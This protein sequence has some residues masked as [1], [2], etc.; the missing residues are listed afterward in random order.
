MTMRHESTTNRF[1]QW[2]R[3]QWCAAAAV[4]LA[5]L[6]RAAAAAPSSPVAL[7][8]CPA[9]DAGVAA[10]LQKM[11]DQLG[12]IGKLVAG[13]TVAI[14]IN[15]TGSLRTRSG[16]RPAWSNRWTHPAVIAAAVGLIGKAGARRIRVL[17]GSSEDD[18]PLEENFVIGGWDPA[19]ILGAG[20]NVEMENTG[21]LGYGKEYKRLEVPGGGTIYSAFDLNHSYAECDVMVSMAKMKEDQH[22]GLSLSLKNMV[23]I[24]PGTIYGDSAGTDQPAERPFGGRSMFHL[25][26]RQPPEGTPPEKDPNSPRLPGYRI[27]RITVDLARARPVDLAII[28]GIET[29]TAASG[30]PLDTGQGREIR[31]VKPGILIASL[32]PVC[33]DAVA[34]AVMGFDPLA[35]RGAAPFENCDSTLELAE[36]AGIGARDPA[37]FEVLGARIAD[38]RKPFR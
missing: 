26:N 32:N 5:P 36:R 20:P 10:G 18:H 21:F 14:K 12:G 30:G 8:R 29:Q 13:K 3:R 25:G 34:A 31:F 22:A 2:T 1:A 6:P 35:V 28:D 33:A 16:H 24:A 11:F 23:G 37:R 9:Y 15:M 27:P 7:G 4:S 38:V 17:E 19:D